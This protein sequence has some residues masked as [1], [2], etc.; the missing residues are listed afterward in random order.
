MHL[1]LGLLVWSLWFVALYGG[2]SV[3]CSVAPPPVADG[4]VTWINAVLL[5]ITLPTIALLSWAALRCWQ[6][7][8]PAETT[9]ERRFIGRQ[10]AALYALAAALT[11]AIGAPVLL[12]PPCV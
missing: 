11:F 8:P 3:A 6:A 7:T 5:L 12:L 9:A 10:A 2:L 4:A 1:V